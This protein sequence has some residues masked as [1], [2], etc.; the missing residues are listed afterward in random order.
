MYVFNMCIYIYTYVLYSTYIK[1]QMD[2]R[3]PLAKVEE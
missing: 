3:L 2:T 1:K